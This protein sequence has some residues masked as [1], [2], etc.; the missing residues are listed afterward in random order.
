M[1]LMRR[2]NRPPQPP[3]I[4]AFPVTAAAGLNAEVE[5]QTKSASHLAS[6]A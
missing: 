4:V 2:V 6:E 1:V 5:R 3:L